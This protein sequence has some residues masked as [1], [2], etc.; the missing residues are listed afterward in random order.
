[1]RFESQK[2]NCLIK[3]DKSKKKTIDKDI[4]KLVE[5]INSMPD[6]YTTSS[7]S[8]RISL[9]EISESG[10]KN[11]TK[12]L[13]V[14]HAKVDFEEIEDALK[15]ISRKT[16]W[17]LEES[18]ILHICCCN[19]EAAKKMLK[20][21]RGAGLKRAG[22][23]TFGRKI[24]IEA[25]GTEKL[26]T[27]VAEKGTVIVSDDYLKVLIREANKKHANN[28]KKIEKLYNKINLTS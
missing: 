16:I 20:I 5:L 15:K 2:K 18:M 3:K 6:Y 21:C 19:L 28:L 13:L 14:K 1:M 9:I 4:K 27:I 24:M 23:I 7:C 22:I 17:L 11:E 12:W 26:E 10:R 8:G 25:F